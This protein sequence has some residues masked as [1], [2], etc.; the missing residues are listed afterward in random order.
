MITLEHKD[1]INAIDENDLTKISSLLLESFVIN[2]KYK[3]ESILNHKEGM[4]DSFMELLN[5][6]LFQ[7]P[8][9]SK[10]K[11]LDTII[12]LDKLKTQK[13]NLEIIKLNI[14][15]SDIQHA[16]KRLIKKSQSA[17]KVK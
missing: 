14:S 6:L 3:R 13:E 12:L 2:R 11:K 7:Q 4:I 16:S 8:G 17:F 9:L 10:E 5:K 15:P 1:N